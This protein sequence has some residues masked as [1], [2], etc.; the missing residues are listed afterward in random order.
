MNVLSE[1]GEAED[2]VATLL[3]GQSCL[4]QNLLSGVI[5]RTFSNQ[6]SFSLESGEC[7]YFLND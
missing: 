4:L 6:C 1:I 2:P 3:C 7:V 5:T